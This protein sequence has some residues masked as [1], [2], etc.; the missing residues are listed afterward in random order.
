MLPNFLL[1]TSKYSYYHDESTI[2]RRSVRLASPV[3]YVHGVVMWYAIKRDACALQS[4]QHVTAQATFAGTMETAQ[5]N[6]GFEFIF[7]TQILL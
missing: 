4:V 2:Y 7:L 3:S 5:L 6:S 1:H